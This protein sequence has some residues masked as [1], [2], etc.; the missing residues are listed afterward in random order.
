MWDTYIIIPMTNVLLWIY[1]IIGHNFGVA[2]IL[3][4]M[5]IRA[6]TWPLTA[7]QL[8]G[9]QGIKNCKPTKNGLGF[10]KKYKDDKEKPGA[11]ANA[12]LQG[13]RHQPLWLLFA[14]L[15][16]NFRS[17]SVFIRPSSALWLL[18]RSLC[19]TFSRSLYSFLD[20]KE[21]IPLNSTFLWMDLGAPRI[22]KR[23]RFRP[24]H[25][26][27]YRGHHL[28]YPIQIDDPARQPRRSKRS[29]G[30]YD[31]HLYAFPDG[32]FR[33]DI[34]LRFGTLLHHQQPARR[35]TIRHDGTCKLE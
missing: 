24:P 1:D 2:I 26:S 9:T 25:L 18:P 22:C 4:T 23:I 14:H 16:I 5:L 27:D 15:L 28:L 6:I 8:K 30:Q 33:H 31:E 17:S 11:G 32:L 12:H 10:Q 21:I 3:F 34:C 20:V 13:A 29:D 35:C 7:Q 19:S